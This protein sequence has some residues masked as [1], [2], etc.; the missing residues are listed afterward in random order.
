ME[1]LVVIAI[2]GIL[3]A[4][5]L[6]AVQAARE[7]ARRMQCTNNLKQTGLAVH[8]FHDAMKGLPPSTVG[9]TV[10]NPHNPNAS[11]WVLILP[12]MEQTATYDLIKDKTNNFSIIM[13]NVNFWNV[14]DSNATTRAQMQSS[15]SSGLSTFKC[16]SRRSG[17]E[18][19][20]D[21]TDGNNNQGGQYGPQGDYAFV[22]G[23]DFSAWSG[24]LNNYIPTA[25]DHASQQSGAIRV[26]IWGS[27]TASS[28]LPRDTMAYW[29]DGTSN[30]I[31]V[32]EKHI[33][34]DFVGH[35]Q[36]PTSTA[37]RWEV[38][39][40]SILITGDWNTLS[41][42]RSLNSAMAK[43]P[44]DGNT[45][46]NFGG[47]DQPHWGS[48]HTGVVNF[49]MGDGSVQSVSVTVPTGSVW[50]SQANK[51][52]RVTTNS[53]LGRLGN[54]HDGNAVSLP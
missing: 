13:N 50:S 14:L 24:W 30:Q 44:N 45:A 4:L 54:V 16:P 1:L 34:A 39:D 41:A 9:Y 2:I 7:A 3:I 22:Q 29:S 43:G 48:S 11:F 25:S 18:Y 47:E 36:F 5:L 6:P 17:R 10:T 37:L 20:A 15:I 49:L 40:C 27:G 42:A 23:R 38:G 31:V 52:A 51:D 8:N 53:I 21:G 32:G 19:L 26:A 28:W 46:A 12:Y 33:R 35:C